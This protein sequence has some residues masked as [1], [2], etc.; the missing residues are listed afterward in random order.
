[1]FFG[2]FVEAEAESA[3]GGFDVEIEA[4]AECGQD[5]IEANEEEGYDHGFEGGNVSALP[6]DQEEMDQWDG[7]DRHEDRAEGNEQER[8]RREDAVAEVDALNFGDRDDDHGPAVLPFAEVLRSTA[9][10]GIFNDICG[11]HGMGIPE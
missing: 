10:T 8:V 9:D 1:M 5:Q 6:A 11:G 2:W 7:A 3:A 4:A